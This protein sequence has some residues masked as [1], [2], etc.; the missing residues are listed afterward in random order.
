MIATLR[1]LAISESVVL[2][3]VSRSLLRRAERALLILMAEIPG[4]N[5]GE[6]WFYRLCRRARYSMRGSSVLGQYFD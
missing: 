1:A 3:M 4:R 2:F 6:C 5:R